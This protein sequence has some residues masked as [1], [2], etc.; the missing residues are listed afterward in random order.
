MKEGTLIFVN[1]KP[2]MHARLK[3]KM[4][5]FESLLMV[6]AEQLR[7]YDNDDSEP[8][9]VDEQHGKDSSSSSSSSFGDFLP[10]RAK[11]QAKPAKRARVE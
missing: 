5:Q 10:L 7:R 1:Q 4:A 2:D 6:K 8:S 9:D 11:A 3:M